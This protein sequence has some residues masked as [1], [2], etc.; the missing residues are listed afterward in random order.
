MT[1]IKIQQLYLTNYIWKSCRKHESQLSNISGLH[2][3]TWYSSWF[4]KSTTGLTNQIHWLTF[5]SKPQFAFAHAEA[6]IF[7]VF[8]LLPFVLEPTSGSYFPFFMH[9]QSKRA[10]H[11]ELTCVTLAF[12]WLEICHMEL[13]HILETRS[14]FVLPLL[15]LRAQ[16][17]T[18]VGWH[19]DHLNTATTICSPSSPKNNTEPQRKHSQPAHYHLLWWNMLPK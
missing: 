4:M 11:S 17:T 10:R 5:N 8:S 1:Y 6:Q 3:N 13:S 9:M 15:A 7:L 19:G 2:S 12:L 18:T 16:G 14:L